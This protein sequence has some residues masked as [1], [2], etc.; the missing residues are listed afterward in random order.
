MKPVLGAGF[1]TSMALTQPKEVIL[2]YGTFTSHH[3]LSR[4]I[5]WIKTQF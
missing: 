4:L 5:R 3:Y 2:R 1:C